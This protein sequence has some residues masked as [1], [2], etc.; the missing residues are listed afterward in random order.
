MDHYI[1]YMQ[2]GMVAIIL[3]SRPGAISQ[4]RLIA[5][6]CEKGLKMQK[7]NFLDD[8][9]IEHE[10]QDGSKFKEKVAKEFYN[11]Y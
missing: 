2:D 7:T 10:G 3:L 4:S 5:N 9:Y 11:I 1:R 8:L 6:G